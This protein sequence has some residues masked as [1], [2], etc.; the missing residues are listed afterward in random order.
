MGNLI[1]LYRLYNCTDKDLEFLL[2]KVFESD[3]SLGGW[4]EEQWEYV[5]YENFD[6]EGYNRVV[7]RELSSISEKVYENLKGFVEMVDRVTE[8][9]KINVWYEIP[10]DKNFIFRITGF[11]KDD[12]KIEVD[13]KNKKDNPS[14]IKK[15]K[16]SEEGFNNFLY[17]P[18]LFGDY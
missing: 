5:R 7:D 2:K 9:H 15:L 16:F 1:Y 12:T 4:V 11:D 17:H 6:E 8:K 13:S 10:K 18:E 3:T 14:K